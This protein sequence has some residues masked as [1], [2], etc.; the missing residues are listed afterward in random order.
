MVF[1]L[2]AIGNGFITMEIALHCLIHWLSGGTYL[3]I[4]LIAGISKSVFYRLI[5][6]TMNAIILSLEF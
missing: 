5:E 3:N 1:N 6:A 4:R 2:K